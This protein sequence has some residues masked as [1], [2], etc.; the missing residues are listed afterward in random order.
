MASTFFV[1]ANLSLAGTLPTSVTVITQAD[2]VSR[3]IYSVGDALRDVPSLKLE[4]D[5][6]RG[7][8]IRPKMRGLSSSNNVLVLID[9]RPLTHEYNADVDLTQIP[10]GMVDRIEITRGGAPIAYSAQAI[11]GT[12]NIVTLK[13]DRKGLVTDLGA[14]VGRNGEKNFIGKFRGRSNLG[15]LTYT[16]SNEASGGFADNEDFDTKNHF[17]NYTRSL[18]GKGYWGAE[19]M[20][21]ESR[22]GVSNG[23]LIPFSDWNGHLEQKSATPQAQRTQNMQDV[24]AFLARPLIAGGT[25]YATYTQSWRT[26]D[27]RES[28][29]GTSLR[30]EEHRTS[31]FDL[32]WKK[33]ETEMGLQFQELKRNVYPEDD[34]YAY[35]SSLFAAREW[36]LGSLLFKPGLRFDHHSRSGS[37]FA[38]RAA[39]V[40][41]ATP[42]LSFSAT[43]QGAHRNPNFDELFSSSTVKNNPNLKD[44]KS[45]NTD[46]GI[47][48]SPSDYVGIKSTLFNIHKKDVIAAD[49]NNIYQN[50]GTEKSHGVETEVSLRLGKND[51]RF[52]L[53]SGN[54]TVQKSQRSLATTNGYVDAA[55]SPRQLAFLKIDKH[56]RHNMVFTNEVR[57]QSEQFESDNKQGERIPSFYVWNMRFAVRILAADMYVAMDNVTN[58]RYAEAFGQAPV[59]GGGTTTV[60]SPQPNR[61]FWTGFSVRFLN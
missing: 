4:Q 52:W 9:G 32:S 27:D 16:P 48:W 1:A 20:Y 12:I 24:R 21:H 51:A 17:G 58:R 31:I 44:E 2:L 39:V 57:Y 22:V 34:H 38:P 56:L 41:E 18:N 40:Y 23:T 30:H 59:A 54:W 11:G 8:R 7:T 25:T 43:A 3:N 50:D 5:G 14:G 19:Y 15:D 42:S 61:S 6:S 46:V 60:L 49:A 29:G 13:P 36:N 26:S 45:V 28:R 55:M 35:T 33:K 37:Y 47:D 53:F 10:V